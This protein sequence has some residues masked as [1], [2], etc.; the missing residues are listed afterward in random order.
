MYSIHSVVTHSTS[1]TRINLYDVVMLK[2]NKPSRHAQILKFTSVKILQ[3]TSLVER[4]NTQHLNHTLLSWIDRK[5]NC[6]KR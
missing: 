3:D 5:R 2:K 1:F 6:T 4:R